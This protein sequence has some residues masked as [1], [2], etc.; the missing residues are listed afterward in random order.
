MSQ[1]VQ[2]QWAGPPVYIPALGVHVQPGD[3]LTV[4]AAWADGDDRWKPTKA[5]AKDAPTTATTDDKE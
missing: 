1:H 5:K 2:A 4:P 3:T